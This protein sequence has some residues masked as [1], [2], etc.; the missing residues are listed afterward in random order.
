MG[1][2]ENCEAMKAIALRAGST[3]VELTDLAKPAPRTG[4]VLV[5]TVSCGLCGTDREIIRRGIPDVPPGEDFLVLGHEALGRVEA[6]GPGT[7]TDLK[8]GDLVTVMVRR[9]CGKCNACLTGHVDYCYT[10]QYTERGIHKVHGFFTE[11]FVDQP[12][13]VVPVPADL[14]DLGVLAEPMSVSAKAY[15]VAAGLMGRVCFDGACSFRARQEKALVAGHGPIGML[16]ALLLMTEGYDVSVLGRRKPGDFQRAFVESFGARYLDIT[17]D[18][19]RVFAEQEGGFLLIIEAAGIAELTFRLPGLLSRNGI[20]VL[21]GVPRGPQEICLDG[22][23]LM[24]SLVR[25]NQTITG[26]VNASR[27]NFK[28]GLRYLEAFKEKSPET[29]RGIITSR[30]TLDNWQDAFGAKNQDEIK[31]V[32]EFE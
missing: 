26:T 8:P 5:K 21:T 16:A 19:D 31:A 32:I 27:E 1:T 17:K 18:E 12:Q 3:S 30:Y 13:Y 20:L 2:D 24:A 9:G 7:E 11:Y 14:E 15:E 25:F 10:G 4:E 28:M 22:N 29:V 23:T 6:L